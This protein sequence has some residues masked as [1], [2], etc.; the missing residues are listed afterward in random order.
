M[1]LLVVIFLMLNV[2]LAV[3]QLDSLNITITE[4]PLEEESHGNSVECE[5]AREKA[6]ADMKSGFFSVERFMG[7]TFKKVD[8]EFEDFYTNYLIANYKIDRVITGC[9]RCFDENCYFDEMYEAISEKYG[10][11]FLKEIDSLARQEYE[12]F[13]TLNSKSKEKY[14]DFSYV[15][16]I[17][18]VRA[19]Y[20]SGQE[21]F[22]KKLR[23]KIDFKKFDFKGFQ[24]KGF[25]MEIIVNELGDVVECRVVTQYFPV[26]ANF[27]ISKA[28]KEIGGWKPADLY[29]S[30]VKSRTGISFIF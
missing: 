28:V 6:R 13:K 4:L 25:H 23:S 27:E 7:L 24:H 3:G 26:E 1:R 14:I 12:K 29:G 11:S 18:D 5:E 22:N 2:Q 10:L 16:Q 21:D 15:Y 19:I 30:K 20:T 8:F 17:V 9:V